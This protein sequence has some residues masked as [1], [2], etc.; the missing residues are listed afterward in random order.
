M[1]A[2]YDLAHGIESQKANNYNNGQKT[3]V[4]RSSSLLQFYT[5]FNLDLHQNAEYTF[6][7]G[8]NKR[9]SWQ[10]IAVFGGQPVMRFESAHV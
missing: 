7:K 8:D 5:V 2:M 6:R 1:H 3:K 10:R 4:G 9:F